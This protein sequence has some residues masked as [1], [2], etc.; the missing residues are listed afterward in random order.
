MADDSRHGTRPQVCIDGTPLRTEVESAVERVVVDTSLHAPDLVEIRL[1][2]EDR[3]VLRRS[4]VRIG[5]ILEVSGSRTGEGRLEVLASVEVTTLE[6][7]FGAAGVFGVPSLD[8]AEQ[9]ALYI[10]WSR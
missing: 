7:D 4:G 10:Y 2:D 9:L 5:S 3:D 8:P 6:H 1:R